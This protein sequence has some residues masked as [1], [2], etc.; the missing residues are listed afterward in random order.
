MPTYFKKYIRT[1]QKF[2][3]GT[4]L[5]WWSSYAQC[6]EICIVTSDITKHT[7]EIT[8][9]LKK[10]IPS[11]KLLLNLA[12]TT[13]RKKSIYITIGPAALQSA[14]LQNNFQ[15]EIISIFTSSQVYNTILETAPESRK[16]TITA[17]FAE[18]SPFNQLRLIKMI[19]SNSNNV[20]V[21]LSN[22]T[23]YVEKLLH[24]IPHQTRTN[25]IIK[26]LSKEESINHVLNNITTAPVILAIP[27]SNIYSQ[28]NI[29]NILLTSYRHNQSII[30]FSPS[31]VKA[32]ALAS[33]YSSI[34]DIDTQAT[35]IVTSFI[36]TGKLPSPQFPKYF[37]TM[38]NEHVAHSLN[39]VINNDIRY[40]SYQPPERHQ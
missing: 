31:F 15:G 11:A 6:N 25:L 35:E 28:N 21:I 14:L 26:K 9:D 17:I 27:D 13:K 10:R 29:R 30:G 19:Y 7:Q 40:F 2:I 36:S 16:T 20:A 4:I 37:H 32:G 23:E 34:E 24:N 22:K 5:F 3:F 18:P 8:S 38:V 12:T 1:C 33:T 39:I